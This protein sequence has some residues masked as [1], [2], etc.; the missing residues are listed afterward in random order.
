M[1]WQ[2]GAETCQVSKQEAS[3]LCGCRSSILIYMFSATPIKTSAQV[4]RDTDT[5]K[6]KFTLKRNGK[7]SKDKKEE[8]K[9]GEG[10]VEGGGGSSDSLCC[11]HNK[12][13]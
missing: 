1:P 12:C 8:E 4:F 5:W 9:E 7:N 2:E 11:A 3:V 6:L 10:V 13:V